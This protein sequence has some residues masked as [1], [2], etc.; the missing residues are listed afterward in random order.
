MNQKL[1]NNHW[2]FLNGSWRQVFKATFCCINT[3]IIHSEIFLFLQTSFISVRGGDS[4]PESWELKE[5]WV[6]LQLTPMQRGY[7][8]HWLQRLPLVQA[9]FF[10]FNTPSFQLLKKGLV[11]CCFCIYKWS[12]M[13]GKKNP[14]FALKNFFLIYQSVFVLFL[15]FFQ[16]IQKQIK[17]QIKRILFL[18]GHGEEKYL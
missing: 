14:Y 3:R 10:Y 5:G 7:T 15:F 17:M 8:E 1:A 18:I 13:F 4:W 2:E 16:T 6:G 12:Q 11:F 9:C